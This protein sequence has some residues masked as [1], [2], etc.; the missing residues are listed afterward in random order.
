[1][2]AVGCLVLMLTL[3][4]VV[5]LLVVMPLLD[6]RGRPQLDAERAGSIV[7][8]SEFKPGAAD[9]NDE[10][11]HHLQELAP[12]MAGTRFPVLIERAG[13][14]PLGIDERRRDAV[15]A[16]LEKQGFKDDGE[17]VRVEGIF[18]QWYQPVLRFAA[19]AR[20]RAAGRVPALA[21]VS[22]SDAAGDEV[23]GGR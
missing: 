12:K 20:L 8:P 5:F 1:M 13:P 17:R 22:L 11:M 7:R 21:G 18:G 9:L 10:G 2:T 6:V 19:G 4:G 15:V 23:K 16:Y 3:L 14:P